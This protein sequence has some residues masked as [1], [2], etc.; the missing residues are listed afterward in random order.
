MAR[1]PTNY[2]PPK[3]E[4]GYFRF[5]DGDNKIRI[6]SEP[7]IGYEYFTVENKPRRSKEP[8]DDP[9]DIRENERIKEFRAFVIWNYDLKKIQIMSITQS[10]IKKQIMGLAQDEDFG[11]PVDYD[12]KINKTGE[13]LETQYLVKALWKSSIAEEVAQARLNTHIN[14]EALFEGKDPFKE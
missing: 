10:S 5:N 7:V 14:L 8:F 3:K 13:K 6:L 12:L 2:E 1:L 9:M 11:D 4:S